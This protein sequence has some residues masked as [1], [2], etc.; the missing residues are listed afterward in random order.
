MFWLPRD[1][2][3]FDLSCYQFYHDKTIDRLNA[4]LSK[5]PAHFTGNHI[6]NDKSCGAIREYID[7]IDWDLLSQGVC[8]MFHGDM[9]FDNIIYNLE[10]NTF[11]FIDW[12]ESFG[13]RVDYGDMYYDLAKLYGGLI[14]SYRLMKDPYNYNS[15]DLGNH[16]VQISWQTSTDLLL[17]KDIFEQ[18]CSA[19]NLSLHKIKLITALIYLNMSPLH[20]DGLDE[21]LFYQSKLMLEELA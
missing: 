16:E 19:N 15:H 7:N 2:E 4:F 8:T 1:V 13:D 18:W 6:I 21:L 12:R 10:T 5:K 14:M 11:T 20:G 3:D 17:F 9:Q